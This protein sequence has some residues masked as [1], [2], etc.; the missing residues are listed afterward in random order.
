MYILVPQCHPEQG[1]FIFYAALECG[2]HP[3]CHNMVALPQSIAAA[4]QK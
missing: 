3:H 1:Y 4:F 2:Y